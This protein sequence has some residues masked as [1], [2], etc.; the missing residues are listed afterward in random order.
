MFK[1]SQK[2]TLRLQH[3][4]VQNFFAVTAR[5]RRKCLILSF[6]EDVSKRRQNFV[7]PSNL[8]IVLR[9]STPGEFGYSCLPEKIR[10][11]AM[12]IEKK[13]R[14]FTFKATLSLPSPSWDLKVSIHAI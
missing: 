9:N 13:E 14:E 2:T 7:S 12:K 6:M 4:V 10:I 3:T 11:I 8:D 5:L 1:I